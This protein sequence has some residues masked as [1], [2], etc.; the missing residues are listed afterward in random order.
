MWTNH[1]R[2]IKTTG[3]HILS[4]LL[5]IGAVFTA[6]TDDTNVN[7]IDGQPLQIAVHTDNPVSSRAVIDGGYLPDASSIVVTL[8]AEDGSAYDGQTFN[9]LLYTAA[10]EG[11]SQIWST[12]VPVSLSGTSAKITAYYP[13]NGADDLDLTAIPVET[14]SQTDYM[15]AKPVTGLSLVSPVADLTMQHALTDIRILV[16]KGT[17]TGTGE[18]TKISVK[19]PAFATSATMDIESGVLADVSGSGA[20]FVQELNSAAISSGDVVH[21][22]LIVPDTKSTSG[23]VSVVVQ[24]D[25]KKFA[26]NVPYNEAFQNN[27]AYVFNLILDNNELVT[28]GVSVARWPLKSSQSEN[29]EQHD[30][31]Y[32]VEIQVPDDNFEYIH[33]IK[34]YNVDMDWG[35]GSR[36]K[37]SGSESP[38]HVYAKAGTYRL[39]ASGTIQAIGYSGDGTRVITRLVRVGKDVGVTTMYMAFYDQTQ[40]AVIDPTALD[41]CTQTTSFK[42]AFYN[43]SSLGHLPSMLF[44]YCTEVTDMSYTFYNCTSLETI[45]TD[46]FMGC[47]KATNFTGTFYSC[48]ALVTI[49]ECLFDNCTEATTM[50]QTF[51]NCTSL[52]SIPKGLFDKCTKVTTFLGAFYNCKA[53]DNL[54]AGL[55]SNTHGVTSFSNTF[56]GCTSLS[57]LPSRLF[58]GCIKNTSFA[59]TFNG[60]TGIV[61]IA[62]DVFHNCS[63]VTNFGNTFMGCTNLVSLPEGLF[64][65]CTKVTM[66]NDTFN[67]CTALQTI[68]VGLFDY[69][70]KVT[71]FSNAFKN[72]ISLTGESPYAIVDFYGTD[73]KI[74]LYERSF[75]P[76]DFSVPNTYNDCFAGCTG[77]SDYQAM[78]QGVPAWI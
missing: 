50:S 51:Y 9:N 11:S 58:D 52:A 21:D 59:N 15:Y 2:K 63:E 44:K 43:C 49:P 27:A 67:G 68:P 19:A 78:A 56:R 42:Y 48:K 34:D 32:I 24:V 33:N 18:V 47:S 1:F 35:D 23:E 64:D 66:F 10:G 71:N 7:R 3:K 73:T 13:Y 5:C 8:T 70:T 74:H 4:L 14:A 76:D 62:G 61:S 55:F 40:L 25:G 75:V 39:S 65:N 36:Q 28:E 12:D 26:V 54:P 6:C 38:S 60:C 45:G 29:F 22:F 31:Q 77:L 57:Y 30:S 53:L 37:L 41:G 69:N 16:K 72:C 17:Y 46:V 20:Q